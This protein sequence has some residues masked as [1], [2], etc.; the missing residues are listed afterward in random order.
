MVH[1]ILLFLFKSITIFPLN[2]KKNN[3]STTRKKVENNN[4]KSQK[5]IQLQFNNTI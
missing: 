3:D 1:L 2:N 5:N 4:S